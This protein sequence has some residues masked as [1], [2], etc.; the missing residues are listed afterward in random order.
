MQFP[1]YA[2]DDL[3]PLAVVR[4]VRRTIS[5]LKT[6]GATNILIQVP[7]EDFANTIDAVTKRVFWPFHPTLCGEAVSPWEKAYVGVMARADRYQ[8][9]PILFNA[10]G[11]EHAVDLN[12]KE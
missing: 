4:D 9:Q 2:I 5:D 10:D 6:R 1:T 8:T 7:A 11:S 12:D 3:V